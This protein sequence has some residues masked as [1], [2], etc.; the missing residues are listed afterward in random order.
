MPVNSALR[1][2]P[3]ILALTACLLALLVFAHSAKTAGEF[4][5]ND[6]R[7]TAY[8]P[9]A[10]GTNYIGTFETDNDVDWFVFYVKQYSQMDF[11]ATM[12]ELHQYCY[13]A[14]IDLLDKD[15]RVLDS[16]RAGYVNELSHLLLTMNPGRYYLEVEG[17]TTDRYRIRIDPAS[18]ITTSRECGEAIVAKDAVAPLL[19]DVNRDLA[20]SSELLAAE[21]TNVHE[22]KKELRQASQTA[23]RLKKKVKRLAERHSKSRKLHRTR[24]KLREVRIEARGNMEWLEKAKAKRRP[25]WEEKRS[26]EAIAGQHQQ[27]LSSAEAQITTYC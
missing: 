23:Q 27:E 3:G 7:D 21:A 17:C 26:L 10:G 11:S 24:R 6:L 4:E 9:L 1:A 13:R 18:A 19:V 15:G 5:S 2:R 12:L 8:G 20:K 22:A 14:Y 16:F 25:V